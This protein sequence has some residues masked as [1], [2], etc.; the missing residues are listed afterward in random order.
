MQSKLQKRHRNNYTNNV[1]Y[2]YTF[3]VFLFH[4]ALD[5]VIQYTIVMQNE[6][7]RQPLGHPQIQY[8]HPLFCFADEDARHCA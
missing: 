6:L 1:F 2:I 5:G 3:C 8:G 4:R 7:T